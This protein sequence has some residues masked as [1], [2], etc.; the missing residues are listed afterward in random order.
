MTQNRTTLALTGAIALAMSA[1]AALG[2]PVQ[3]RYLDGPLCDNHGPQFAIEEL[4]NMPLFPTNEW[5]DSSSTFT[6]QVA[7]PMTDNPAIPNALI[8]MTNMTT[9][10]WQDL[11]YVADPETTFSNVDGRAESFAAAGIFTDAMRI[12]A[13]G[14]NR[15]L[16]SES[17]IADGLFQ[18]GETWRFI[19]Q[20]YANLLGA[21]AGSFTSLDFAGAS[22]GP[23]VPGIVP[24]SGSIVQMV[25]PSPATVSLA[26]VG[27]V[28]ALRRRRA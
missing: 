3:G 5:I 19:V 14:V 15:N 20:D 25:V 8:V 28:A 24:S 23:G 11:Y 6:Q 12:D 22:A 13:V 7:C 4:G 10:T 1:G 18:P 16:I 21:P 2:N 26:G 27:V 17:I 9:T